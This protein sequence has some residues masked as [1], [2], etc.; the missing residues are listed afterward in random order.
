M[1]IIPSIRYVMLL[2]LVW[3]MHRYVGKKS[4]LEA[5]QI[6]Y[7]M[8]DGVFL[9]RERTTNPGEYAISIR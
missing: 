5:E 3:D 4:R 1:P 6:L 7:Q 2:F 9:V 8:C